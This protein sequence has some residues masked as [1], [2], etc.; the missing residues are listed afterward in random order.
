MTRDDIVQNH[1]GTVNDKTEV[2]EGAIPLFT[3]S[4]GETAY[5]NNVP[6]P[7]VP[8]SMSIAKSDDTSL[9]KSVREHRHIKTLAEARAV[10]KMED[11]PHASYSGSARPDLYSIEKSMAESDRPQGVNRV[12]WTKGMDPSLAVEQDW[13]DYEMFCRSHRN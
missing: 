4:T 13:K 8:S 1:T 10:T 11:R 6:N 2:P 9:Y 7:Y 3:T 5:I 12:K